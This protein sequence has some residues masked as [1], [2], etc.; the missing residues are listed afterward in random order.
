MLV[1]EKTQDFQANSNLMRSE[2]VPLH[3]RCCAVRQDQSL[4]KKA[5]SLG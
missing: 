2:S 5:V 3:L 4:Q 1:S